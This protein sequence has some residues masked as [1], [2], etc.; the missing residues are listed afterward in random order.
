MSRRTR[1]LAGALVIVV[2]AT[3]TVLFMM[4]G[5]GP[6]EG[7]AE[8]RAARGPVRLGS[9]TAEATAP[10]RAAMP[11]LGNRIE[12]LVSEHGV[13]ARAEL[14]AL[15]AEIAALRSRSTGSA[16]DRE[17][18]AARSAERRA[19]SQ[20][21]REVLEALPASYRAAMRRHRISPRQLA[22]WAAEHPGS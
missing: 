13:P 10:Q 15:G 2:T 19:V 22:T 12:A 21:T 5:A 8:T 20:R 11:P 6:G 18:R 14:A 7:S 16:G 17:Q 9:A 3:A 4:S 1:W